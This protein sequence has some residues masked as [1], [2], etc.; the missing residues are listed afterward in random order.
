MIVRRSFD[1]LSFFLR[2]FA[3]RVTM[4]LDPSR[5]TLS[6]S[7]GEQHLTPT[8]SV[9]RQE[10][11]WRITDVGDTTERAGHYVVNIFSDTFPTGVPERDDLFRAFFRGAV[12]KTM[13]RGVSLRPVVA[14]EG[15]ASLDGPQRDMVIRALE[16]AGAA[17]VISPEGSG[18]R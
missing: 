10:G 11:D 9:A 12:R 13:T 14:V 15:L 16:H 6:T 5:V 1:E 7:A 3:P 8:V 2:R 17:A 4:R 18:R